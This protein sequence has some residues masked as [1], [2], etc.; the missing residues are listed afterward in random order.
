MHHSDLD[1]WRHLQTLT[2]PHEDLPSPRVCR[3]LLRIF[4]R[5]KGRPGWLSEEQVG[6]LFRGRADVDEATANELAAKPVAIRKALATRRML[7]LILDPAVAAASGSSEIGSDELIVGTMP[8]FSVGQGKEFVRYLTK[9]EELA[10]A[11]DFLNELSPMGHIVPNHR[12]MLERGLGAMAADARA[13]AERASDAKQA[14]FYESVA[15]ALEA[16]I[17]FARRY[18]E[19]ATQKATQY[20]AGDARREG[21]LAVAA[22]LGVAPRGPA[23]TFHQAL[24]PG[25]SAEPVDAAGDRGRRAGQ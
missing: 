2:A 14:A 3:L 21:L 4:E 17:D 23:Q 22:C 7:E 8:P 1:Y 6:H 18:A 9:E 20:A 16:V 10:G 11:L 24:R 25:R 19:L 15:I 12:L 5:W 13:Q